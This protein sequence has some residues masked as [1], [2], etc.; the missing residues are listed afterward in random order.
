MISGLGF[1]A[2]AAHCQDCTCDRK[3]DNTHILGH[4]GSALCPIAQSMSYIAN[5]LTS[6]PETPK[7]TQSQSMQ[8]SQSSV[9]E[10]FDPQETSEPEDNTRPTSIAESSVSPRERSLVGGR[11][12]TAYAFAHPPPVSGHKQHFQFRP[13]VLL[14]LQ[15]VSKVARPTPVVEVLPSATFASRVAR[16]LPRTLKDKA[17]LGADDLVILNS[18][19]YDTEDTAFVDENDLLE[20]AR[21]DEREIISVIS[22]SSKEKSQLRAKAE[23]WMS[24]GQTWTASILSNG[25]YEFS[26]TDRHGLRRV[27]RWVRKQPY[28][29]R[30]TGAQNRS[31]A[32]SDG[33]RFNFSLL[34]PNSRRHAVIASLD[35]HAIEVADR[36]QSPT[37]SPNLQEPPNPAVAMSQASSENYF[38]GTETPVHQEYPLEVDEALRTLIIVT[39]IWVTFQEGISNTYSYHGSSY[40]QSD[41]SRVESK[42]QRRSASL[43]MNP[44][45]G[46]SASPFSGPPSGRP[47]VLKATSISAI[48]LATETRSP[49]LASRRRSNSNST[50]FMRRVTSGNSFANKFHSLS[51]VGDREKYDDDG[52]RMESG[53]KSFEREQYN[54]LSRLAASPSPPRSPNLQDFENLSLSPVVSSGQEP[55]DSPILTKTA[56]ERPRRLSKIFGRRRRMEDAL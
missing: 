2:E 36:Y 24:H 50:A 33:K 14:Q 55:A 21:W 49:W 30:T 20:E 27:A 15:R 16:R 31:I 28:G 8:S 54:E 52:D 18:E 10:S 35:R 12:R 48:P 5:A 22:N 38:Q 9:H 11:P 6:R 4:I 1:V 23:I 29:L 46:V 34:N 56:R 17:G 26:S 37:M 47:E 13:K 32:S 45:R 43:T 44:Y 41:I 25:S 40:G 19:N 53:H 7:S 42:V 51:Q 39:G 3:T